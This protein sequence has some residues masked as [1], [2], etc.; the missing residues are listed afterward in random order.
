MSGLVTLGYIHGKQGQ[1]ELKSIEWK[2]AT[3][4]Q[5]LKEKSA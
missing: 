5:E 2:T 3:N 4:L 1:A